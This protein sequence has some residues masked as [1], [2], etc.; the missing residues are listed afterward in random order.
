MTAFGVSVVIRRAGRVLLVR[1]ARPPFAG[2]WSLPGGRIEPGESPAE[3]IVREVREETGLRVRT[4]GR[5]RRHLLRA[6]GGPPLILL[7]YA[8]RVV[9]GRLR[10][11]ADA[12]AVRWTT[13][14]ALTRRPTTPR[15][16]AAI[17]RS[18]QPRR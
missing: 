14:A 17:R 18:G 1:R 10:P 3:A 7:V 13:L 11:G 2:R 6:A 16:A 5:P 12:A 9:G 4:V 8:A 15:L